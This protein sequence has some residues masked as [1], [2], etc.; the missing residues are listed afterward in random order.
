MTIDERLDRLE[1]LVLA[2]ANHH[3]STTAMDHPNTHI[4]GLEKTI[5]RLGRE[6]HASRGEHN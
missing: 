4:R 3:A 5:E 2:L 1:Q 6:L